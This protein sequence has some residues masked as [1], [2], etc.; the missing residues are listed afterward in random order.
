MRVQL[1]R[2]LQR[3]HGGLQRGRALAVDRHPGRSIRP[4]QQRGP[5]SLHRDTQRL[6]LTAQTPKRSLFEGSARIQQRDSGRPPIMWSF[7]DWSAE[8]LARA[9]DA[10]LIPVLAW[11]LPSGAHQM[12]TCAA[13]GQLSGELLAGIRGVVYRRALPLSTRELRM[14]VSQLG[15]GAAGG[16]GHHP[17]RA[18][19]AIA[20]RRRVDDRA[21]GLTATARI[22]DRAA[23]QARRQRSARLGYRR[24]ER[25][26]TVSLYETTDRAGGP[27]G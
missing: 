10:T 4:T 14:E 15:E 7:A 20:G 11:V 18:A 5:G 23:A 1:H 6:W 22:G 8:D 9:H 19:R 3:H 21:P 25:C 16:R 26:P 12:A 17:A 24:R 2:R 27:G 13:S